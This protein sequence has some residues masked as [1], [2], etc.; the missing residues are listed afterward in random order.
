M[1]YNNINIR[2]APDEIREILRKQ[3]KQDFP[4]HMVPEIN[5]DEQ[6]NAHVSLSLKEKI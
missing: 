1:N 5:F 2:L 3:M 6:G 4:M